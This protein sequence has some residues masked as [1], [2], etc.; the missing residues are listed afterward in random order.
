MKV[1][2]NA[3]LIDGTGASPVNSAT[4]VID[5]NRITAVTARNQGDFPADSEV[6]DVAGMTVLPG[7]IDCHDHMA[8]H[9][10]DMVHRWRL[11][12]PASTRHL[13]TAAVLRH[14]L[15]AGYTMIR[16]AA[17]LD[18]GFKRAIDEGLIPGPRLLVTIAIISPIGGIGDLV[19]PSGASLDCCCVPHDP[20]LPSGVA[21]TLADIRP[22]VRRMVR[23][24][25]DAIKCATTGGASS[26]PGHGPKD[27]AFNLDELQALVDEA[28][29][30]DRKVMCHA[31]GGAGL[32]IAVEA[33]VDS[34][35]H[36]TYLDEHPDLIDKMATRN[37]FFVPTVLVY[38]YHRKSPQPH[39]RQRALDLEE[40]HVLSIRRALDAGV[41][42]VAGTDAGGHG[43]PANA[44]ELVCLV[45]SGMTPMQAIQAGTSWAA[46]CIGW[47]DR[48]GTVEKGKLADLIVVDGD[49]LAEIKMLTESARIALVIKDGCRPCRERFSCSLPRPST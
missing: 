12:E 32:E 43:H 17:G 39:V 30:L 7:L 29:A 48:I 22:V 41:K 44:G 33:G 3:R 14:T 1:L 16:D 6:I 49:P 11:D 10:Y 35:E 21:E 25:A 38:D 47:K 46:E 42:V 24:S 37:I 36:G 27:R 2:K 5:G 28:H 20:S 40:H 26:R 4:I 15:E 13:R 23:A 34:I 18:A 8:N 31:L 9:R 45:R 19:S